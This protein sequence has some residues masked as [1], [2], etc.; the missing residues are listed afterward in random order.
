M[1][2]VRVHP[3]WEVVGG[4]PLAIVKGEHDDVLESIQN[5]CKVRVKSMFRK[6][7]KCKLVGTKSV[8]LDGKIVTILK[9][10]AK[11][12]SVGVGD[13]NNWGGYDEGSYNVPP[14]MLEAIS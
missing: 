2:D 3:S 10:N 9:V 11:T 14:R 1:S 13:P 6:G 4:I 7:Q 8:E 5:A 12:V